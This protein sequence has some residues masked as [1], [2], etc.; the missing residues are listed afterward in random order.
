M[1]RESFSRLD[2]LATVAPWT[3]ADERARRAE[4]QT[5]RV[6]NSEFGTVFRWKRAPD[7]QRVLLDPV[8]DFPRGDM[9]LLAIERETVGRGEAYGLGPFAALSGSSFYSAVP[10]GRS[11]QGE[12]QWLA[13]I[14]PLERFYVYK[15]PSAL[16]GNV[17]TFL[18]GLVGVVFFGYML[19]RER[20]LT[21]RLAR[22]RAEESAR[23]KTT[24]L[25]KVSHELRTPLQSLLGYSQLMENAVT[26]PTPRRHLQALRQQGDLM[27]RLVNDLLDL[28]AI[29][30]GAFR[31]V[32]RPAPAG[33][34]VE[35][36][37][38]S[39][40]PT[41]HAKGLALGVA[42]DPALPAWVAAD[43]ERLRQV[44]LNLISNAL[45][46]TEKGRVD[47]T[48][49]AVET[50]PCGTFTL[51]LAVA[52][53]GPGIAPEHHVRLFRAFS[54]LELATPK[55]GAGLG[56]ALSAAL[57][58]SAGGS[59]TVASDGRNG[60]C[61]TAR[62]RV[63]PADAPPPS[64]DATP[65]PSLRGRRILVV[66]DN[67]LVRDLFV[68]WLTD[69][70]ARCD[71]AVDGASAL[72]RTDAEPLDAVVIDLAMPKLDGLQ[73]T[74]QW[75]A[76]GRTWR[77]VG[78]SA[79]AGTQERADAL[80]AGMDAFLVKPVDIAE[81]TAALAVAS[82]SPGAG[83]PVTHTQLRARLATLFR[84][85]AS[86]QQAAVAAALARRDWTALEATVHYLKSSASV[87]SDLSLYDACTALES[88]ADRR[89]LPAASAAWERCEQTLAPWLPAAAPGQPQG[90]S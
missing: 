6:A 71:S 45:K 7:G 28:S 17:L 25:A 26:E 46:F 29:E 10:V 68:T 8:A 12:Q 62:F 66:D 18:F 87:V 37:V 36:T 20:A 70:G 55:E 59:L 1:S 90:T 34:I 3:A 31:L 15:R 49:R 39:M 83:D 9:P 13:V 22:E 56:L 11:A 65:L 35:Q 16:L 19:H 57:C 27:L 51:E 14:G 67:A 33:K 61:F 81:L 76:E 32:N 63:V 79:H 77:I 5:L 38:A 30:S 4:W 48:L 89:D 23:L 82:T 41:A 60:S 21:Q 54:R 64:V 24:F 50:A 44:A 69:L 86:A 2:T 85:D 40:Q 73:V 52:D 84:A 47:V 74:R 53:T 58:R 80:A 43:V 42:I 78:V 88:A 72:A 75:R